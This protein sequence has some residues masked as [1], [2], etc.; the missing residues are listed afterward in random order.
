MSLNLCLSNENAPSVKVIWILFEFLFSFLHFFWDIFSSL[1]KLRRRH[2]R[3]QVE[4]LKY[5][6]SYN[7]KLMTTFSQSNIPDIRVDPVKAV[8]SV[9]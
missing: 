9:R 2:K 6:P 4:F 7:I 8:V 3:S 1:E 5:N